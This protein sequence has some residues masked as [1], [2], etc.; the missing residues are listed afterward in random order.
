M[1]YRIRSLILLNRVAGL[2]V[3]AA[4]LLGACAAMNPEAARTR[5]LLTAAG[6]H[7]VKPET[8]EQRGIFSQM[9]DYTLEGGIISGK[10]LYSYKDPAKDAVYVGGETEFQQYGVLLAKW[11]AA[12]QNTAGQNVNPRKFMLGGQAFSQKGL[13]LSQDMNR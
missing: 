10:Q 13:W 8:P 2:A 3:L 4:L 1:R 6:F 5:G 11:K 7:T 12:N 9:P